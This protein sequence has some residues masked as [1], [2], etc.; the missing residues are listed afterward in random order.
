MA[1]YNEILNTLVKHMNR[2]GYLLNLSSQAELE[3]TKL[4]KFFE[5]V[6]K[7]RSGETGEP[8]P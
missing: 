2:R 7:M 5:N 4:D 8:K 1:T 3:L 6:L